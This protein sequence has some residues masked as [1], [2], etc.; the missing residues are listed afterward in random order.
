MAVTV[1]IIRGVSITAQEPEQTRAGV[2][3][4]YRRA[5]VGRVCG[6]SSSG[7]YGSISASNLVKTETAWSSAH[8]CRV[9]VTRCIAFT[10]NFLHGCRVDCVIT[11]ALC[12]W[13]VRKSNIM[14]HEE[15]VTNLIIVF[16][17][18]IRISLSSTSS[19]TVF[20]GLVGITTHSSVG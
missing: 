2:F 14:N 17:T 12:H 1:A 4:I 19:G 10:Q 6:H 13:M 9:S 15:A 20:D 8:F 16:Q 18:H 11:K 5:C 3:Q 7:V